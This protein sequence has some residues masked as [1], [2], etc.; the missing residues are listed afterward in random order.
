MKYILY[1]PLWKDGREV[2]ELIDEKPA[3][4][5]K[6][7]HEEGGRKKIFDME[8]KKYKEAVDKLEESSVGKYEYADRVRH[9]VA[10]GLVYL[11]SLR[12]EHNGRI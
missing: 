7:R 2:L 9:V 6:L 12:G 4:W 11:H 1:N 3:H 5:E 10:A 8:I